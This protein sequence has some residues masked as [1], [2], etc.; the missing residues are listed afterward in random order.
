MVRCF[1]VFV[2]VWKFFFYY[3]M[4]WGFDTIAMYSNEWFPFWQQSCFTCFFSLSL[5]LSWLLSLLWCLTSRWKND[6]GTNTLCALRIVCMWSS[7]LDVDQW[8]TTIELDWNNCFVCVFFF[9]GL[10]ADS[11]KFCN[12]T[13]KYR[14]Q[15]E[16]EKKEAENRHKSDSTEITHIT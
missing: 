2:V 1:V 15:M 6:A 16:E 8:T 9:F 13:Q 14:L 5:L 7:S 11:S 4:R 10:C 12:G 3:W